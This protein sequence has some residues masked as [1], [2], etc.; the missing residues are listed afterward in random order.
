[1]CI[2]RQESKGLRVQSISY[3]HIVQ[4]YEQN[5]QDRWLFRISPHPK[6]CCKSPFLS[7]FDPSYPKFELLDVHTGESSLLLAHSNEG[8][9]LNGRGFHQEAHFIGIKRTNPKT[10][11]RLKRFRDRRLNHWSRRP[12]IHT[13]CIQ[14]AKRKPKRGEK[15]REWVFML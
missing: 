10:D 2:Q 1:M 7:V 14:L 5:M 6:K 13:V 3:T 11:F 4:C 12:R 15:E 9:L 8:P